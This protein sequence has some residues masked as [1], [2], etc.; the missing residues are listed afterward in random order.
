MKHVLMAIGVL[1]MA[2]AVQ[3][4]GAATPVASPEIDPSSLSAGFALLSG[5]ALML[6]SRMRSR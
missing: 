1:S 2:A 4:T 6:R 3:V 5:A